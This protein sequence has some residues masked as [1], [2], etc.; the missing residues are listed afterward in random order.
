MIYLCAFTITI[1]VVGCIKSNGKLWFGGHKLQ[2][3]YLHTNCVFTAGYLRSGKSLSF[4]RTAFFSLGF[5][6]HVLH[7]FKA[8]QT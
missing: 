7:C 6:F 8:L 1:F 5:M 4:L 3:P 2:T